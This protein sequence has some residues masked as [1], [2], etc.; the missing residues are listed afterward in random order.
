LAQLIV[1]RKCNLS[2]GYCNE[3]DKVS[4]PVPFDELKMRIDKLATLKTFAITLTGGE[5]LLHPDIA[6]IIQY[7]Q[8]TGVIPTIIT[9]G[10]L[11]TEKKIKAFNDAGL[12]EL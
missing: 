1:T 4:A 11:L 7:V 12:Q 5:P 2:C 3:Y 6:E 10:Y 8:Q 9:N